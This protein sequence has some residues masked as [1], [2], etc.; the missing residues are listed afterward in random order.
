M[1]TGFSL[2][3][4]AAAFCG[5]VFAQL[6]NASLLVRVIQPS[7]KLR[8]SS[9]HGGTYYGGYFC[10][11]GTKGNDDQNRR[12]SRCRPNSKQ[13]SVSNTSPIG[14]IGLSNAGTV[15]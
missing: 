1:F 4:V 13:Y 2:Q 7:G 15:G 5:T 14:Q 9:S 11:R 12:D 8:E 6:I 3:C 10:S